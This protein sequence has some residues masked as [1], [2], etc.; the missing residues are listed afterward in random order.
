MVAPPL[1]PVAVAVKYCLLLIQA[2][3]VLFSHQL[4]LFSFPPPQPLYLEPGSILVF[5]IQPF[6]ILAGFGSGG[7]SLNSIRLTEAVFWALAFPIG[8]RVYP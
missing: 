1:V 5:Q 7:D 6:V 2:T 4:G 8:P 3:G